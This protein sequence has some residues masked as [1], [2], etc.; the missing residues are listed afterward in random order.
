[1]YK[2]VGLIGCGLMA[3]MLVVAMNSSMQADE[4]EPATQ[5]VANDQL[6]FKGK[7][8]L[9]AVG[10]P[11]SGESPPNSVMLIDPDVVR[12]GNKNFVRGKQFIPEYMEQEHGFYKDVDTA[13]ALDRID[14]FYA[15]EPDQIEKFIE[16]WQKHDDRV[17]SDLKKLQD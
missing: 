3:T 8:V 1:M 16:Y 10:N 9:F 6:D 4:S 15:F 7:T 11:V 2:Q 13:I 12:I 17:W 5:K 14:M